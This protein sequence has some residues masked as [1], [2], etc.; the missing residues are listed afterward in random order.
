MKSMVLDLVASCENRI[1]VVEELVT[2]THGTVA[3]LDASLGDLVDERAR[4]ETSLRELLVRNCSLRRK[5]FK[6]LMDRV[7]ADATE[8]KRQ[9]E[10]ER[11]LVGEEFRGYLDEQKQL[12]SCLRQQLGDF[13]YEQDDKEALEVTVARIKAVH[14][15]R[16]QQVFARLRDFQ[17]RLEAFQREQEAMNRELARLVARGE[18][19]Q[20]EDLRQLQ[21]NKAGQERE[22]E[23]QLRRQEVERL[24]SHFK[25]ERQAAKYQR[26]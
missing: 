24:L 7:I 18:T 26:R 16:G 20:L 19:L 17:I 11:R 23:R 9:L 3:T 2:G 10:E 6:V 25:E 12:V 13:S 1:A 4:L 8:R 22:T 5:D 15:Q 21:A 14:Q